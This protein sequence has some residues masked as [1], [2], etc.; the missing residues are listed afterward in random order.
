T[1]RNHIAV[2][3]RQ[4]EQAN[5]VLNAAQRALDGDPGAAQR[6]LQ[7]GDLEAANNLRQGLTRLREQVSDSIKTHT[8][9]RDALNRELDALQEVDSAW[10]QRLSHQIDVYASSTSFNASARSLKLVAAPTQAINEVML[11]NLP[12]HAS[13]MG[14]VPPY[15]DAIKRLI[16][17]I[18]DYYYITRPEEI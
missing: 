12:D 17:E 18:R 2:I 3:N 1:T 7:N 14:Y 10:S 5:E 16:E 4:I 15:H 6:A 8:T 13:R 9:R 11:G